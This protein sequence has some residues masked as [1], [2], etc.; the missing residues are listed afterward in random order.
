MKNLSG[1]SLSELGGLLSRL[2]SLIERDY[3]HVSDYLD[4]KIIKLI[5]KQAEAVEL[6]F[7]RR[8]Q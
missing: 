1:N 4:P 3:L 2:E 8:E 6:E 7:D 5:K